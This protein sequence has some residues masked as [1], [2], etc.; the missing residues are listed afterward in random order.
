[1]MMEMMPDMY[2]MILWPVLLGASIITLTVGG[3]LYTFYRFPSV[4]GYTGFQHPPDGPVYA[5]D[6]ITR[7]LKPEEQKVVQ[8]LR[9]AG[10]SLLQKEIAKQTGF[11]R[12]KTHRILARLAERQVIKVER[13]GNTNKITLPSWLKETE[14]QRERQ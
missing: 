10:G 9:Q 4:K 1:M 2:V 13:A 8:I 7:F 11:P 14:R 3:L 5:A 6:I 12:L